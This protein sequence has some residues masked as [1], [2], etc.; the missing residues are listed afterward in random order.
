MTNKPIIRT[1]DDLLNEKARLKELLQAQKQLIRADVE[2][3]KLEFQPV[4]NA[5]GVI[6]KFTTRDKS[7]PLLTTATE[8]VI[9]L[10]VRKLILSRSGWL[11][12][13]V[14]PFLM[15]N[16]SSHLVNENQGAIFSKLF[17][18]FSKKKKHGEPDIDEDE[19]EYDDV[20]VEPSRAR[21]NGQFE[22]EEPVEEKAI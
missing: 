12:K 15:K 8:T 6:G 11:T 20:P 18:L 1:Y 9:D 17:S 5:I 13:M 2:E 3:I 10:V 22:P 7:N 19:E 4:K 21:Q 16:V 14:V